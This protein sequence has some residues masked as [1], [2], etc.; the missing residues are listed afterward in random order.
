M[1][2]V[3]A[4]LCAGLYPH[5]AKV[6]KAPKPN[7]HPSR[8]VILHIKEGAG[9]GKISVHPKSVNCRES[10]FESKWLIYYHML[11]TSQVRC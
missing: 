9:K 8:T 2:L 5:V 4:V 6:A 3:K 7:S 11:K 1:G 10:T